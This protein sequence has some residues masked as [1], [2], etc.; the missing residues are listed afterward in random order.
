MNIVYIVYNEY[1]CVC[2][3]LILS[4]SIHLFISHHSPS[5]LPPSLPPSL[6][7]MAK[8]CV[9]NVVQ[10]GITESFQVKRQVLL[11][12]AEA[13]EMILRVDNIV[14]AAPR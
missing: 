14:K 8:G 7:D 13:A 2:H 12:A 9:G 3:A 4:S 11:S 6:T 1:M 5:L 10:L